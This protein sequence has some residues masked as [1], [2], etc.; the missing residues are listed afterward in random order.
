VSLFIE[1][2]QKKTATVE[3][4]SRAI[5]D[6]RTTQRTAPRPKDGKRSR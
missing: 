6:L 5:L 2:A 1:A 3:L 4:A